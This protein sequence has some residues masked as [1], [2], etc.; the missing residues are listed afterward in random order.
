MLHATWRYLAVLMP[1]FWEQLLGIADNHCYGQDPTVALCMLHGDLC[2]ASMGAN[3]DDNPRAQDPQ[4]ALCTARAVGT[5]AKSHS[6][7][8]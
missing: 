2:D 1:P 8:P 6:S 5:V 3:A 4:V 7:E